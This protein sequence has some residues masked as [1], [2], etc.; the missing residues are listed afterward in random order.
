M[1]FPRLRLVAAP[2]FGL[3]SVAAITPRLTFS[4]A[5]SAAAVI[6]MGRSLM[7]KTNHFQ[8]TLRTLMIYLC[9]FARFHQPHYWDGS[10]MLID[11]W[12]YICVQ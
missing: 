1:H 8:V 2:A 6:A 3:N 7:L 4:G 5:T 10:V 12:R 11:G 9:V